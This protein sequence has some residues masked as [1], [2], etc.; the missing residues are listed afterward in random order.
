MFNEHSLIRENI[1][2]LKQGAE[3]LKCLDDRTYPNV[4][5]PFSKCGIGSHFRHCMDFYH[6]F[7]NGVEAGWIDYDDRRRDELFETDR[8]AA[9]ATIERVVGKLGRFPALHGHTSVMVRLEDAGHAQDPTSWSC[10]SVMRELQSLVSHTVHHYAL[11]A[12]MLQMNG[13]T[14]PQEFG[15]DV[16]SPL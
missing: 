8:R 12:I 10:S 5:H 6:A 15:A 14:L 7:L 13:F 16:G 3:I 11:I 9:I 1:E 4:K 2:L